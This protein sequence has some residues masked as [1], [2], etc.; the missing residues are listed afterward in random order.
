MRHLIVIHFGGPS[1]MSPT[2]DIFHRRSYSSPPDLVSLC[3]ALWILQENCV[4]DVF[5][6]TQTP[7]GQSCFL[8]GPV[9][10]GN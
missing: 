3:A 6:F 9:R 5:P 1:Q 8:S 10:I 4:F 7:Q 2:S